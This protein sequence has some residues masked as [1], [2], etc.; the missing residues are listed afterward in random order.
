M[1]SFIC[2]ECNAVIIDGSDGYVTGCEHYSADKEGYMTSF[3]CGK[4]DTYYKKN[5]TCKCFNK[6]KGDKNG[7]DT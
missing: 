7:R 3:Y 5:E 4:C 2:N 6:K 1:S